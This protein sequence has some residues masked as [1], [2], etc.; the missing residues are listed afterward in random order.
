MT[1]IDIANVEKAAPT[2]MNYIAREDICKLLCP[3]YTASKL[4][5]PAAVRCPSV[6]V[7]NEDITRDYEAP[8]PKAKRKNQKKAIE[9]LDHSE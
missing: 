8:K 5:T 2:T 7:V 6:K 9:K 1:A 3:S 4:L